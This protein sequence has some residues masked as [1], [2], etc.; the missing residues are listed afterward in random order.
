MKDA[1]FAFYAVGALFALYILA[2]AWR[3]K[4]AGY[5]GNDTRRAASLHTPTVE[6]RVIHW[7]RARRRLR[8][9]QT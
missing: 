7:W 8:S 2:A 5:R 4:D 9:L 3:S 6:R 1:G